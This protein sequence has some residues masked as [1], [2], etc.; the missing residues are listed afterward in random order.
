MSIYNVDADISNHSIR[1][2]VG[3]IPKYVIKLLL[4]NW[5]YHKSE[6]KKAEKIYRH[7]EELFHG[8]MMKQAK[9]RLEFHLK[10]MNELAVAIKYLE[11]GIK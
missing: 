4:I 9:R 11:R 7:W 1:K 3:M 10:T 8:S 5:R 6:F 2:G